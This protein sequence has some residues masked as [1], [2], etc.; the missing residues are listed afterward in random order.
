MPLFSPFY[1]QVYGQETVEGQI[2]DS[3]EIHALTQLYLSTD[4]EEWEDNKNWLKANK[5]PDWEGVT[6]ENGDVV[7][8]NLRSNGLEGTIPDALYDLIALEVLDL[9]RNQLTGRISKKIGQLTQM[10][11]LELF[12]NRLSGTFPAEFEKLSKIL[13]L[14]VSVNNF[15]G[16]VPSVLYELTS[17]QELHIGANSFSG[18]ITE[19]IGN[20]INL[21]VLDMGENYFE[22]MLPSSLGHLSKLERLNLDF[23]LLSGTIPGSFANLTS[24]ELLDVSYNQL[25]GPIPQFL[26]D[27]PLRWFWVD[28][29]QFTSYPDFSQHP[30]PE[31]L[32]ITFD[33]NRLD[34]GDLE[35]NWTESGSIFSYPRYDNQDSVAT[36]YDPSSMTYSVEV[37]GEYNQYQWFRNG[38]VITGA[39]TASLTFNPS[40]NHRNQQGTDTY[41]CRITNTRITDLTLWSRSTTT[42]SG[43]YYAIADGDWHSPIWSREP[44]GARTD[45]VPGAGSEVFIEGKNVVVSRDA[46]CGPVHVV[47]KGAGAS[48]VVDAADLTIQGTLELTKATEGFPGGVKAVNGGRVIP[49]AN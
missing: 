17:L 14:S 2:P 22:G 42:H 33:Q 31:S 21:E 3:V 1:G 18:Q 24:L 32:F 48:L 39:T 30:D 16:E 27:L 28:A 10:K 15:G 4:G 36:F 44:G 40:T 37:A 13:L 25:S 49:L 23:N 43:R 20:L 41:Q 5:W 12:R 26:A 34:F 46:S 6:Y 9:S 45:Q 29:N 8:L 7:E 35:P 19:N 38:E 47:I 11:F